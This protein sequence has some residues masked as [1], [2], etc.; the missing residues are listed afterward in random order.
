MAERSAVARRVRV[1]RGLY[2]RGKT[3]SAC[4][5]Q[6]GQREAVWKSLGVV[7]LAVARRLRDE[8]VS[9]IKAGRIVRCKATFG[10]V[11]GEWL[12]GQE[13]LAELGEL[14]RR[15]YEGYE[16]NLR[17]H[18]LPALGRRLIQS[19][20]ADDLVAWTQGQIA[21]GASANS[22]RNRYMPLRLVL[23]HAARYGYVP[24]NVADLLTRR[25]RPKAGERRIHYLNGEDIEALIHH[26][27]ERYRPGIAMSV[28]LGTR[29]SELL[30]IRW[31]DIDFSEGVVHITGQVDSRGQRLPYAKT[32]AGHREIVLMDGLAQELRRLKLRSAFSSNEEY[33]ISSEVGTPMSARNIAQRGLGPA[34]LAANLSGVTFHVLRHTYASILIAQGNDPAYVAAQMGHARPSMT[35]D[36]YTFLFNRARH[37]QEHRQ[38]LDEQFGDLFTAH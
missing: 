34:C 31:R 5:T 4:A 32:E 15:T 11:A 18:V 29:L 38:K 25:E 3:Y 14:R 17:L 36:T 16:S 33:V 1:E 27:T 35:L 23:G 6:P 20:Q 2:R 7:N 22:V 19:I 21:T 10:K 24:L 37:A 8:F 13:R 26:A 30:G 28:F 9:E 12:Q